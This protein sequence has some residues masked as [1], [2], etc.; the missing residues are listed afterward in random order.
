ML[1]SIDARIA[2]RPRMEGEGTEP[3]VVVERFT[4]L[5]PGEA[6]GRAEST[7]TLRNTFWRVKRVRDLDVLDTGNRREPY[8]LLLADEPRF[9]A[10]IGCNQMVGGAEISGDTLYLRTGPSTRMACPPPQDAHEDLFM[11][12]LSEVASWHIDGH[13][14]DLRDR[15]GTTVAQFEAAYLP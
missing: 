13:T 6:C 5:H 4:A 8:L 7:P 9:A 11:Q 12:V 14:L 15:A 1:V 3:S 2:E 10:T